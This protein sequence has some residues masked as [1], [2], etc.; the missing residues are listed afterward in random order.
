MNQSKTRKHA[1]EFSKRKPCQLM[2]K[3]I[4]YKFDFSF[5][6]ILDVLKSLE[7]KSRRFRNSDYVKRTRERCAG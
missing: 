4:K 3:L 7:G 2:S 6:Y 5:S 1:M